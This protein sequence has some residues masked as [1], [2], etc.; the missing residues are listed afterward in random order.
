M[1]LLNFLQETTNQDKLFAFLTQAM[2][3][4]RV[5]LLNSLNKE[6]Y[7]ELESKENLST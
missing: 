4:K 3:N 2:V 7:L 1:E 6:S 5:L